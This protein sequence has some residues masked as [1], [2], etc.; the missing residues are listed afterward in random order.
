[1]ANDLL[2]VSSGSKDHGIT[3]FRIADA[4]GTLERVSEFTGIK[5]TFYI[6]PHPKGH[7]VYALEGEEVVALRFD[8]ASGN[9]DEINRQPTPGHPCY[10]EVDP[11]GRSVVTANYGAGSVFSYP[12]DADGALGA[13]G[14]S[15]QHVG[16]SVNEKRQEGPHAHCFKIAADGRFAFAAD[17]GLDKVMIYALDAAKGVLTPGE[18]PFAR[19]IPGGGPRHFT[20]SPDNRHGYVINEIGNTVTAFTY[21]AERGLLLEGESVTTIPDDCDVV[22]H[23]ADLC[24]TPDGRFLYGSNR[25]HD[26]VAVFARDADTGALTPVEIKDSGGPSPQNLTMSADG[27]LLFVANS[28]SGKMTAFRIDSGSGKLTQAAETEVPSPMCSKQM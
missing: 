10:V 1:M 5:N 7:A 21:D 27:T 11:T 15:H 16:S 17:L 19:V 2:L 4:D 22:T 3:V 24:L 28:K 8:R 26:S 14:S 23:T 12:I 13:A 25:G 6:D 20:F 9:F 18:Q